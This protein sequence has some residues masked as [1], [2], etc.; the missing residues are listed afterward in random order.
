MVWLPLQG[1]DGGRPKAPSA[2]GWQSPSY[3]GLTSAE[4]EAA[5]ARGDWIGLRTD[6]RV[7]IDCDS[8]A[9]FDLWVQ[10]VGVDN[11]K[12]K[13]RKTPNGYHLIYRQTPGSPDAPAASI[14]HKGSHIDVRA[15]RTSQIVYHAPGYAD[16]GV[17]PVLDFDPAW[18][19][20]RTDL[21]DDV[22]EWAEM[23]DGMANDTLAAIAGT[24]RRKGADYTTIL[25]MLLVMNKLTMTRDPM[26][27]QD[28]ALIAQS[29]C[30]YTPE[31]V[32]ELLIE[33]ES[34][35]PET[36]D[37]TVDQAENVYMD[38]RLM[39][40]P[41]DRGFMWEP[42]LPN[43]QLVLLEGM[44]GI[45]KSMFCA[46]VARL[47]AAGAPFPGSAGGDKATVLWYSAEDDPHEEILPRLHALEYSK[48]DHPVVFFN[49]LKH[50]SEPRFPAD[51]D[52]VRNLLV[53]LKVRLLI[54][55]PGRDYLAPEDDAENSNN[56]EKALRPGLRQLVRMAADT[57]CTI[58]FVHH[59]NKKQDG[60]SREKSTGSGAFRQVPRIVVT[61]A[62]VGS[63]RAM[64]VE[65]ANNMDR[66]HNVM[67]YEICDVD[68][69]GTFV[70]GQKL[71]GYRDLDEWVKTMQKLEAEGGVEIVISVDWEE[72]AWT[73]SYLDEGDL[74]PDA[75]AVE[76][77]MHVD[78]AEAKAI[79]A[80]LR[81]KGCIIG[82]KWAK[83]PK[84][85]EAKRRT[86]PDVSD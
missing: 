86:Q 18:V 4:Y 75:R 11:A 48:D 83:I 24:M 70:P 85:L 40:A 46:W 3:D 62:Q 36:E 79:L 15:G 32:V 81:Q 23:P 6:D 34:P 84:H 67:S 25:K 52:A 9:A 60:G 33:D 31:A 45:G 77:D 59:Q 73:Y 43:S 55:D 20:K 71:D 19:P 7:V 53:K 76:K 27:E 35:E 30:R 42:Y 58:L 21:D 74:A 37:E 64:S 51:I 10:H 22:E 54:I 38:A 66:F 28:V 2:A 57:G 80:T 16:I 82:T 78:N 47:V 17:A 50:K 56:N 44:E 26:P 65:K 14:L 12:T 63:F 29:I 68:G 13:M 41:E 8:K 69:V 39:R 5:L 61:M 49:P 1:P 72:A